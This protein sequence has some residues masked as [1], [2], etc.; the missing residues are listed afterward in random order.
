MTH[1]YLN[2]CRGLCLML[3]LLLSC[4][5]SSIEQKTNPQTPV[6]AQ[7]PLVTLALGSC[8]STA[9][10]QPLWQEI[11]KNNPQLWIW[12]GDNIYGDTDDM[13]VLKAKYD[14]QRQHPDYQKLYQQIPVI[15]VWDDHDYGRNNAGKEYEFK[16]QS[17]RLFWDFLD[18]PTKS[19][20]R[21]QK[22]VYSAHTYGPPG[23]QVKVLL[24]DGRYHRDSLVGQEPK[25]GENN[26]GD[27]LGEAQW[28][29][30]EREL[31]H[32]K[33][34]FHLIGTGLQIIPNEHGYERWGNFPRART[35]LF[36]LIAKTK[37]ANVI[38]LT[39]DRHFAEI[40][41]IQWPGVP[42]PIFEFT[43]SGLTHNWMSG[44]VHERNRHRV[45]QMQDRLNFGIMR[46]HWDQTP[47]VVDFEIRGKN[48][49]LHQLVKVPYARPTK[50]PKTRGAQPTR[51][52]SQ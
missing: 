34:Q 7:T 13:R 17:A 43:S 45:G 5:T 38:L 1:P 52:K 21:K 49:R 12:L 18:E 40:S 41:K 16:A 48:N 44:F 33:A 31:R 22:G 2:L 39:G 8:N 37:A 32:S 3:L 35:R 26:K 30:L 36:N 29:W 20:R 47:Y 24:L 51:S 11:L 23:Q 6:N 10:K 14:Q 46:F 28:R 4:T 9:R 15:G 19:P 27:L 25:Y 42:Y 50:V